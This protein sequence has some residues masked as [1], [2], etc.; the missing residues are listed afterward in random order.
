MPSKR[1][2]P[3]II[4]RKEMLYR[5]QLL[6]WEIFAEGALPKLRRARKT[7]RSALRGMPSR[8]EEL[9][10]NAPQES[11]PSAGNADGHPVGAEATASCPRFLLGLDRHDNLRGT[12]DHLLHAGALE[13]SVREPLADE[14]RVEALAEGVDADMCEPPPRCVRR[15]L[16]AVMD[17][18][19][20]HDHASTWAQRGKRL[21]VQA[22][23]RF[24]RH[25]GREVRLQDSVVAPVFNAP[26]KRGR[27]ALGVDPAAHG[28]LLL[29]D[30]L[31]GLLDN[32]RKVQERRF[33]A[34]NLAGHHDAESART[35]ADVQETLDLGEV[36][37]LVEHVSGR[38]RPVV[39]RLR[40][41]RSRL[42]IGLEPFDVV[43]RRISGL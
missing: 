8:A 11:H 6:S 29:R 27:H 43:L 13:S 31:L 2:Y 26:P 34:G 36:D 32:L 40:V 35:A 41:L 21:C 38:K 4:F 20:V 42:R 12:T 15:A 28:F 33:R 25:G 22:W 18:E 37:P 16:H 19:V 24:T 30:D 1:G 9:R 7:K 14:R 23:E 3:R 39:L 10:G 5:S 17:H